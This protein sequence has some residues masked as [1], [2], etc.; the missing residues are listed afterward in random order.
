MSAEPSACT[1]RPPCPGC[2]RMFESGF[3]SNPELGLRS[4]AQ[5][6]GLPMP[7]L[8]L[9]AAT[10]FRHRARLAVRGRPNSPKI[11]IFQ[12]DSHRIVDIPN[13]LVH[14]P[15]INR[16]VAGVKRGIRR[17]G[18]RPY[19]DRP[20]TGDLR[21]IQLVVERGSQ[22]AQLTLVGNDAAS[23]PL[24]PLAEFLVR[25]LENELHSL[26][27]NGNPARTNTIL[28]PHWK[29]LAG[30]EAVCEQIAGASVLYP[31]GAF[32]QSNLDLA[33]LAIEEIAHWVPDGSRIAEF[34]AG[35]GAIGLG[36]VSRCEHIVFNEVAEASL[37]GLE[38]GVEQ[39][40]AGLRSRVRIAPGAAE[41][42]VELQGRVDVVIAD[43]PRKGLA[44][45]LL[46]ALCEDP[47]ARFVYLSC[48]IDSFLRASA[49]LLDAGKLRLRALSSYALIR[50][51][52]HVET[53][54]IFDR[55][56]SELHGDVAGPE[57]V[58]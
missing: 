17:T 55:I 54:A 35:C 8:V 34:Y 22:R 16:V 30:P 4:L 42:G 32:G 29:R 15:L 58:A 36:L 25:E 37:R 5:R 3:P 27:W 26:W 53:L 18:T 28:G 24:Q 14:H 7:D 51:S 13:C 48:G 41:D 19:A 1:H 43:P 56:G 38:L 6:A 46:R 44:P 57:I 11:G 40:D 33:D 9:G 50:H 23:D 20:H 31:P 21:S 39:L 49:A 2:P 10:G 52:E 12:S 45:E 47:P